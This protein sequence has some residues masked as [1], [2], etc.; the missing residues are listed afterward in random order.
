MPSPLSKT[1]IMM[2]RIASKTI[3]PIWYMKPI[4]EK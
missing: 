2:M 4:K 1:W 3:P